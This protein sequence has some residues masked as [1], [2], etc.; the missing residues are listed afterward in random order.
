M[1]NNVGGDGTSGEVTDHCGCLYRIGSDGE[2]MVLKRDIG[3]SNTVCFSP[4][5]RSFY[6]GDTPRN[7]I[8]RYDYHPEKGTI[9]NETVF[10]EGFSR[11]LPDGST[12][13]SEGYLWNCRFG[14]GCI[15]RVS[16]DGRVDSVIEMPVSNI[17][18]CEFG[19]DDLRQLY[20]TT[21]AMMTPKFERLAGSLFS[22]EAPAPGL[23]PLRAKLAC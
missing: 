22:I 17:T 14:G 20:V 7:V 13:D 19:G 4:D 12:V 15:V 3:I 5:R 8:W 6:F 11:G 18:T 21:A 2:V 16:P 10:F 1:A 23:E 9:T